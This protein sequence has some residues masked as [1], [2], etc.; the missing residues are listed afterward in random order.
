[1]SRLVPALV[2]AL[3][4][5]VCAGPAGAAYA[6]QLTATIDPATPSSPPAITTT[7]RQAAGESASRKVVVAFPAGFTAP[8]APIDVVPCPADQQAARACGADSGIGR[9]DATAAV[10]GLPVALTGTVHYAGREGNAVKLVVYLDNAMLDQH[11]TVVGLITIRRADGGFDAT[12]DD[13]P[14][15]T[16]TAFTLALDGGSRS[17]ATTP[18]ACGDYAF[19]ATFTSHAGET[20]T[21]SAPVTISGCPRRR[22]AISPLELSATRVRVGTGVRLGVSLSEPARV[23]VIVKGGPRNRKVLDRSFDGEQG[24]NTVKRFGKTFPA[25]RYRIAVTAVDRDG[26]TGSRKGSFRVL[27]RRR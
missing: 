13:L 2:V 15:T 6:P 18:R 26:D 11:V 21:S 25:G 19:A 14:D 27:P 4:T 16:T 7:I 23:R 3:L 1:M 9:A 12:F 24:D 8:S 5:A 22:P 10:L 17:L 20:A